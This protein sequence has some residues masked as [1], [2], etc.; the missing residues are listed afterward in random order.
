MPPDEDHKR[1]QRR[2][3]NKEAAAK[4]RRKRND[5]REQLEKAEKIL[6]DE[7]K[8]LERNVQ[9]LSEQKNQL[10]VLLHRH[11]CTKKGGRLPIATTTNNNVHLS[12]SIPVG[13]LL[14]SNNNS[15]SKR[16]TINFANAQDL[17]AMAPLTRGTGNLITTDGSSSSGM[18]MITIHIIPEVAQALLGSTT[19]DKAKLAELLQQASVGNSSESLMNNNNNNNNTNS[20]S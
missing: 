1:R 13:S 17:F 16:V 9:T 20:S 3:R 14:D 7:Q 12:K 2:D 19:V 11:P 6:L 8:T 5:L 10:E 15:N 18:P 4:C